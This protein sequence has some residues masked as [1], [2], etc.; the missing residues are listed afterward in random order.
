GKVRHRRRGIWN[1]GA[2]LLSFDITPDVSN[3]SDIKLRKFNSSH[4]DQYPFNSPPSRTMIVS[5]HTRPHLVSMQWRQALLNPFRCTGKMDPGSCLAR[6][7]N[8]PYANR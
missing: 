2:K 4:G 1:H 3:F 6:S 8:E 5:A 7:T